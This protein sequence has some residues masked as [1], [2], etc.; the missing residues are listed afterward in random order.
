M[1]KLLRNIN[2]IFEKKD[3]FDGLY[4]KILKQMK[5]RHDQ[6]Q[7][8][9]W[10]FVKEPFDS[11]GESKPSNVY[12]IT[13]DAETP[14]IE[15][16]ITPINDSDTET[17][18]WLESMVD[19]VFGNVYNPIDHH[20]EPDFDVVV[21]TVMDIYKNDGAIDK[22]EMVKR[23]QASLNSNPYEKADFYRDLMGGN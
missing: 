4:D 23:V 7:I 2:E 18:K 16:P 19:Y 13:D 10:G 11:E 6:D 1:R 14:K 5:A 12:D 3:E 22:D 9:K 20:D 15:T 17:E 8:R 21:D